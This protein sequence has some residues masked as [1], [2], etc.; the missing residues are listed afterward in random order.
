MRGRTVRAASR[1]DAGQVVIAPGAK[2][3]MFYTFLAHRVGRQAI[4]P[5][6]GFPIYASMINFAGGSFSLP[7]RETTSSRT[8]RAAASSRRRQAHRAQ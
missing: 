5:D 2:P 8:R 6:P 3:I 4:F 7:L 1:S